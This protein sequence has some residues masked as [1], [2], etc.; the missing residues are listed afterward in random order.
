M[1]NKPCDLFKA[2]VSFASP[3][4]YKNCYIY[5]DFEDLDGKSSRL[6]MVGFRGAVSWIIEN[7]VKIDLYREKPRKGCKHIPSNMMI[8]AHMY[9]YM[10]VYIYTTIYDHMWLIWMM[11]DDG[12]SHMITRQLCRYLIDCVIKHSHM[13]SYMLWHAHVGWHMFFYGHIKS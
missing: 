6:K 5:S 9:I 3:G 12:W 11:L 8:C 2:T 1:Q 10:Y 4:L 13:W 7:L